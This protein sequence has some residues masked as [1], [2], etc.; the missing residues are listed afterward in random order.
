VAG[1]EKTPIETANSPH[2][3]YLGFYEQQI[4]SMDLYNV[5]PNNS[6]SRRNF[7]FLAAY[8]QGA[9]VI[10]SVDDDNWPTDCD[11]IGQ[12]QIGLRNLEPRYSKSGWYNVCGDGIYHR[13]YP[14]SHR[15][16]IVLARKGNP[17]EVRAVVNAGLWNGDPD[18]DAVTRL[19]LG[20]VRRFVAH[21]ESFY[22]DKCWCPFNSQNTAIHRDVIPAY[23]MSAKLGRYDDIWA[24]YM[25]QHI[26]EHL[27]DYIA[28]GQPVVEQRRNEHDVW[29]DFEQEEYG[30][31][32][33]EI[34]LEKLRS[35]PLKGSTYHECYGELI[36]NL[37]GWPM[38][39]EME[40]WHGLFS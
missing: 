19:A 23:M 35:V 30:M 36:I 27:G 1:D 16:D 29:K 15:G 11:F 14:L 28:F 32:H 8:R 7:A 3:N 37:R 22:L 12:H 34:F 2:W 4:L 5:L 18:I 6:I 10:I 31:K 26:A 9:E 38:T 13:G 24:S 21:E 17:K 20:R 25:V 40:V 33:T 39:K